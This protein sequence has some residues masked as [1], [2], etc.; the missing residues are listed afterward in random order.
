MVD[1]LKRAIEI[2]EK[3]AEVARAN[4]VPLMVLGMHQLVR[5]LKEDLRREEGKNNGENR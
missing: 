1:G 3:E 2:G 4:N 5:L